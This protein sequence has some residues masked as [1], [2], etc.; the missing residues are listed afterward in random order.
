MKVKDIMSTDPT[1]VPISGTF[2]NLMEMLGKIRFH[3]I[4]VVDKDEKLAGVVTETDLLKV[5]MPKYLNTD[6]ALFSIMSEDYFDKRCHECKN[7][8]ITEIMSKPIM[9]ATAKEDDTIIKVAAA[10]L[11]KKIHAVPVLRDG[12]VVGIVSRLLLLR[13]MTKVIKKK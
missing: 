1:V 2:L 8:S 9:V 5:L 12:K 6:N 13:Y 7:L 10:L 11:N 3:V 4:F